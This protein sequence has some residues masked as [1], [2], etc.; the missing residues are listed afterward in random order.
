MATVADLLVAIDQIA[1]FRLAESWDNVGLLVGDPDSDCQRVLVALEVTPEVIDEAIARDTQ[2]I[3]A[4][5]P[6]IFRPL[7]SIADTTPQT[8][9]L[10]RLQRAN[11]ALI[12]AHTNWDSVPDGTNGEIADRL[13]LI[14]R[15][16]LAPAS[17]ERSFKYAVFVPTSHIA[18]I[19]DAIHAAG[20]GVIGNYTHCTFR[21][22][23]TGTYKPGE[24][25]DPYA[26]SIGNLEQAEE[27]RLETVCPAN[28][29][30]ALIESVNHAH[31]Y[32]EVAYDVYPLEPT[33]PAVYGLGLVGELPQ[34]TTLAELAQTCKTAMARDTAQPLRTIGQIGDPN[35]TV[36]RIAICSGGGGSLVHRAI[37]TRAD[38]YITGE[39]THHEAADLSQAGLGGILLGHFNSEAIANQRLA[40]RL[41]QHPTLQTLEFLV[42]E[43]ESA[44]VTRV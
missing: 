11:I 34:S 23:G 33:A 3:V 36:R 5:H 29:L 32:E 40:A 19:I 13:H 22:P 17:P 12:A 18:Q 30:G 15:T 7:K 25:A 8:R 2:A 35:R 24:G 28:R 43:K 26:G 16:F 31:P 14:N 37:A 20:A 27:V 6:L 21:S 9:M 10:A 4:H 39:M 41:Q 42:S 38:A 1:P 44:P